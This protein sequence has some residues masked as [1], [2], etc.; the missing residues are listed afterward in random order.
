V[1]KRV[2]GIVAV[3][4][5]LVFAFLFFQQQNPTGAFVLQKDD[6]LLVGAALSLSGKAASYGEYNR[7]GIEF[8]LDEIKNN[9]GELKVKFLFDDTASSQEKAVSSAQKFIQIDRVGAVVTV[10]ADETLAVLQITEDN[11]I[12]LFSPIAGSDKVDEL[13]EY[14]FRNREP[15]KLTAFS[16]AQFLID[17]NYKESGL[18]VAKSSSSPLSYEKAFREKYSLLGGV[19]DNSFYYDESQ[20]DVRMEVARLN[21]NNIDAVYVV[22]SKDKD[23]AEVIK[24]LIEMGY[25]GLIV[26]G[27]ALDTQNFFSAAKNAGEGVIIAMPAI[28]AKAPNADILLARFKE[29]FGREMNP[30]EANAFDMVNLLNASAVK[31]GS[32]TDCIK[33]YLYSVK[34]YPGLGGVTT[35]NSFGGVEKPMTLKIAKDGKFVKLEAD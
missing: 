29:R 21:E 26:G 33:N 14:V 20:V 3:I 34:N 25:S 1:N 23:G 35:F 27:P 13:G 5:M 2:F 7:N 24:Q 17:K 16:I 18:F 30:W 10:G 28:N 32:D 6:F 9:G 31:C 4:L 22:A 19:V 8:A 11:N 15:S 12:I